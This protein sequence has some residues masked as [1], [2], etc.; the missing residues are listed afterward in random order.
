MRKKTLQDLHHLLTEKAWQ[1]NKPDFIETDPISIPHRFKHKRDIEIAGFFAA[2]LAWG[3]RVTIIN[4]CN[5]LL[6]MMDNKPYE[7]MLHHRLNDLRP[8][9]TFKHR[10]FNATDALYFI[11]RLS[12]YYRTH[13]SLEEAFVQN[14]NLMQ[15]AV[16]DE[17]PIEQALIQFNKMFFD[18]PD[19]PART[20]K[21]VSTPARKSACK[22]LNMFL[23]WMVR[24]DTRGVDFGIWKNISPSQLVCPCDVH[25]ERIARKFKLITRKGMNWQS[26]IELTSNLRQ[27]NATDPVLYDFALFGM[28]VME[29]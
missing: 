27:L 18:L 6:A 9:T 15:P 8:F 1:Y 17:F 24:H 11:E 25:V 16:A 14:Q 28:G 5:E 29:R 7:F 13:A 20:Q 22:R 12:T 10:T 26:A 3:Q 4:K 23:R 19:A 21:H 2:T